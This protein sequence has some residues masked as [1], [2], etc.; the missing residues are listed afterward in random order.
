[1]SYDEHIDAVLD[2]DRDDLQDAFEI[3]METGMAYTATGIAEELYADERDADGINRAANRLDEQ[4]HRLASTVGDIEEVGYL[5]PR[6]RWAPT[7]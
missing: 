6:Y 5:E 4:L 7:Q 2:D 1:M 3:L